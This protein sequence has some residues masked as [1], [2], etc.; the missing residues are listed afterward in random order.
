MEFENCDKMEGETI[1][2][3][4]NS[5]EKYRTLISD[6]KPLDF[7]DEIKKSANQIFMSMNCPTK[8]SKKRKL[9]LFFC[10]YSAYMELGMPQI[11]NTIAK[12]VG[13]S[14]SEVSKAMALFSESQTGYHPPYMLITPL[15]YLPDYCSKLGF[16][17]TTKEM[18]FEMAKSIMEKDKTLMEESPQKISAGIIQ[19]FMV[20]NG[21][22]FKKKEFA[23]MFGF[24]EVTINNIFKRI[25]SI[26]SSNS[27]TSEEM[28][29]EINAGV[30]TQDDGS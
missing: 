23:K 30:K 28:G 7:P 2:L 21:I 27:S 22:Q 8:R 1:I 20:M 4:V 9:L 12:K 18:V 15:H 24:S 26:D 14:A 25:V 3:E 6:L 29:S 10:I 19:F 13:I 11:P 5:T 16:T 17:D